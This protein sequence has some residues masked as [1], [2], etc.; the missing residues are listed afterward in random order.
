MVAAAVFTRTYNY[1][2][3]LIIM[4]HTQLAFVSP[5]TERSH[6]WVVYADG[7]GGAWRE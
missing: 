1:P 5:P 2:V 3:M 7:G 6:Y 4:K